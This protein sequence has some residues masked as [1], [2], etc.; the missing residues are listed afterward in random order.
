MFSTLVV[1]V[2]FA[3]RGSSAPSRKKKE[4]TGGFIQPASRI[5]ENFE[6]VSVAP[7]ARQLVASG[8]R[9]AWQRPLSA[10]QYED[11]GG[12]TVSSGLPAFRPGP[13]SSPSFSPGFLDG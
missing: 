13:S 5:L 10:A 12:A 1:P 11:A 8:K 2:S 9:V 3:Y 7:Q 4:G 6:A